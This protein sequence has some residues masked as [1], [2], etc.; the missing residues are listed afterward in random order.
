MGQHACVRVAEGSYDGID[1]GSAGARQGMAR[2]SSMPVSHI[3]KRRRMCAFSR[4]S[5]LKNGCEGIFLEMFEYTSGFSTRRER[6]GGWERSP[7]SRRTEV[8]L[9]LA[10]SHPIQRAPRRPSSE[11]SSMVARRAS[12]EAEVSAEVVF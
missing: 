10:D 5:S 11:E 2:G 6:G 7:R 12:L 9:T 8:G 3:S 4:S 1:S